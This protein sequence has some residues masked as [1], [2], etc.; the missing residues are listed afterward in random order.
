MMAKSDPRKTL[1]PAPPGLGDFW[2]TVHVTFPIPVFDEDDPTAT[3]TQGYWRNFGIRAAPNRVQDVLAAVI[4]DGAIDWTE[5]EWDLVEARSLAPEIRSRI[6]FVDGEG[7]WYKSARVF[8]AD[9]D[10]EP[11]PS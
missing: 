1:P 9:T 11:L 5:T 4:R 6:E 10:L 3:P 2:A 8:Y 7:A